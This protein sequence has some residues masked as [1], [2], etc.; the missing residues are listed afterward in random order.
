MTA[1]QCLLRNWK[2]RLFV[3]SPDLLIVTQQFVPLTK[4]NAS[5]CGHL[6]R[7]PWH[8]A[9]MSRKAEAQVLW[10]RKGLGGG[11][12]HPLPAFSGSSHASHHPE[13]PDRT[14]ESGLEPEAGSRNAWDSRHLPT[15]PR[16]AFPFQK[17]W[18]ESKPLSFHTQEKV[19]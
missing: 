3:E 4:G 17:V 8:S 11:A 18:R 9:L 5:E 6:L 10:C 15:S 14:P 19:N 7:A 13:L 1:L 16:P 2:S 12:L